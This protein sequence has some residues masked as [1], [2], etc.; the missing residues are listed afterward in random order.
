MDGAR[1]HPA[2]YSVNFRISES[3]ARWQGAGSNA[4]TDGHLW[5]YREPLWVYRGVVECGV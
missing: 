5:T 1:E 3:L 2:R 4:E